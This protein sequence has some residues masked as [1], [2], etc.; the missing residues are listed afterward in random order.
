MFKVLNMLAKEKF[1]LC[2]MYQLLH[3]VGIIQD[4]DNDDNTKL[5]AIEQLSN[6]HP[7]NLPPLSDHSNDGD[8]R[9]S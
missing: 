3:H 2:L 6:K 5:P 7:H 4:D 9:P 1:L 8:T